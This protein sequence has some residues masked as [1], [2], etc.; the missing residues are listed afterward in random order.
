M[1]YPI[2]KAFVEAGFNV[3]LDKPMVHTSEQANDLI[4]AVER[5]GVVFAVTYNYTGYP[6][7]KQARYMVQQGKLGEIRKVI[8]EYPQDWLATRLE[9]TG[10]KQ[11]DWRTDP[12]RSGIGGCVGD[13]GTHAEN[14]TSTITGLEISEISA[15]LTTFVPGRQLDDDVNVLLHFDNGA[16]GILSASQ[17]CIGQENNHK[18]RIWGTDGA[19]EWVQENPNYLYYWPAGEAMQVMSRGNGYL[20]EAAQRATR[21]PTGHPEAF[22]EAFGNIYLNVTDTIRAKLRGGDP[23][24]LELDFPTVYDGARGV[25]FVEKVVESSQSTVKWLPFD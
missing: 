11:A 19:L 14:L 9:E 6:L 2:A 21:L 10:Q 20:C 16:R 1:H 8:V 7:V 25:H 17:V 15:D 23:T 24:E 18:I 12:K 3:V 4:K 22:I 13:I 5:T